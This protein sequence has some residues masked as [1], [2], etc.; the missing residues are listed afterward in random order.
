MSQEAAVTIEEEKKRPAE[1]AEP[2]AK[3]AKTAAE[4]VVAVLSCQCASDATEEAEEEPKCFD[5]TVR[6]ASEDLMDELADC[7]FDVVLQKIDAAV[8]KKYGDKSLH[9]DDCVEIKKTLPDFAADG[10]VDL[11]LA[12]NESD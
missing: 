2:P 9:V 11:E 1:A 12:A 6:F 4:P 8:A 10:Q 5:I 3:K 7:M